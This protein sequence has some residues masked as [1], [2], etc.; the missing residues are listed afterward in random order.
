MVIVGSARI[1][2]RNKISGG[3]RGDQTKKEVATQNW[4]LHKK[5]WVVLRAKNEKDRKAIAAAMKAACA[6]DN[7]GY[8]QS[9][10]YSLYNAV[11]TLNY[12]PAKCKVKVNTDCSALVRVC[13]CHA[14]III[15]DCNTSNIAAVLMK[16]GKF[17]KLTD[18]RY[19]TSS[20]Y[21]LAGDILV[22][23]TQGHV[24]VVLT[25]GS[26]SNV[27]L[28]KPKAASTENVKFGAKNNNVKLLQTDLNYL[29]GISIDVDGVFGNQTKNALEK[30]QNKYKIKVTGTYTKETYNKIVSLLK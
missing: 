6:N 4:Y 25:N 14:G 5:G 1:D 8:S 27:K 11:K 10:R 26:G 29:L 24:V 28:T 15:G 12:D 13:V 7:I 16:T 18:S 17:D 22:T 19:T 23:K 30:F 3:Q 20:N 2:E 9:D 21:L